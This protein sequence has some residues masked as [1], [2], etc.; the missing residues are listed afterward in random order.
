MIVC[1][2][3]ASAPLLGWSQGIRIN[4]GQGGRCIVDSSCR[5]AHGLLFSGVVNGRTWLRLH[6][7]GGTVM[8]LS[9]NLRF[10]A[11]GNLSL[12]IVQMSRVEKCFVPC[13]TVLLLM[14]FGENETSLARQDGQTRIE[15]SEAASRAVDVSD[16]LTIQLVADDDL[17]PDCTAIATDPAGRVLAS[18]PRYLCE[19]LDQD[20]DGIYDARRLI[21]EAPSH[22]AH[23]LC[24]DGD[25]LYYV[26]D[27]GV[28]KI[29]QFASESGG[30]LKPERVLEI[31]TGGEHD[32]HALRKGP[33]GFWYLIAGNGTKGSFGLQNVKDPRIPS[34]RAGVI[35]RISPDWSKREVWAEGFRNAY[36]FDFGPGQTIDTFDSDGERDISLPWYRPTRVFRVRHG[37]DAGWVSR[38]WKRSNADP[39]MPTVLAELG[40]GSPTGVLRSPGKRLPERFQSGVYV[41]DW[42]F[43]RVVFVSDDG[44]TEL[45]ASPSGSEGFAVTDIV[46]APEG[47]LLVSVGG[48]RSRGGIYRI[49]A[50]KP[51]DSSTVPSL[52]WSKPSGAA[53]NA[54][55]KALQ[56]LRRNTDPVIDQAAADQAV[57]ALKSDD[58]SQRQTL[59]A[60]ALLIESVGGLGPGDPK[61]ARGKQQAAAVF[62]S[63]RGRIRPKIEPETRDAAVAALLDRL[64]GLSREGVKG[65]N[66]EAGTKE[67]LQDSSEVLCRELIRGLAVLEPE[68]AVVFKAIADDMDRVSSPVDKL[69]R[70]IALARIPARRSDEMTERIAEAM[71]AIP[72]LIRASELNVDRNWTPRMGELFL[73][74]QH[75]DSL[76]PSRIVSNQQF[77]DASHLVW[78][79][80]MDPEN[81]E[82]GR[83]KCLMH[84]RGK[85]I[86]PAIARFIAMGPDAVPR[87]FVYK[88]LKDDAT[89]PSAWLALAS[90]PVLKD[91]EDLQEAALSV[92]KV[93]REAAVDALK[94]LD[95]DVPERKSDSASIQKWLERGEAIAGRNGK[96]AAGQKIYSARQCAL[97]HNGGKALGPS[98]SGVAK[99]FSATDLFRA[100]VDPSH[101]IPDRY[102]AKQVLTADGEVVM[103]L[104]VYE[105][106]DGVTLMAS[107]GHTKRVNVDEIE[108]MRWSEVSLMPEGLLM[109]LSDQEVADLLAYLRSL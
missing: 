74:M 32:A 59:E 76:L 60:I 24:V 104:V 47:A 3:H 87:N 28:W 80:K 90:H 34:P 2:T 36:D 38:S 45:V 23:G 70:L 108:E 72:V 73:A 49:D 26:G 94:K 54:V 12:E 95:A 88:W 79:E 22:G 1:V 67:E 41:L 10:V 57:S 35:W 20:S 30:K 53:S 51:Q 69:F 86:D 13:I 52:A 56:D 84:S 78:T 27:N 44:T 9:P 4:N 102:R 85:V 92:D 7:A 39:L 14:F 75:R 62:D 83:H 101:A 65:V 99:R 71:I 109:G 29:D 6:A 98:L 103:G 89:R 96:I 58:A 15:R 48:R 66:E 18:G 81:L 16:G 25:A 11:E 105:S 5:L 64:R 93:V 63:C 21:V 68:S 97:C 61:D 82:R 19:L 33:D 91:V 46:A 43:G 55:T 40:R 107:D 17:V 100:T 50:L 37:Q 77:G 8:P 106:V 31:K 42:T